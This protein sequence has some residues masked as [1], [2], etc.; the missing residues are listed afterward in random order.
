MQ[1]VLRAIDEWGGI[2]STA[3][4]RA[5]GVDRSILDLLVMYG[6][7]VRVKK[8]LWARPGLPLQVRDAQRL[9]GRLACVSALAFHGLIDPVAGP[10]HISAP[11]GVAKWRPDTSR[12]GP[13]RHWSRRALP[14][15]RFAV[16]A[17]AAW[18]QFGLC[19]H[20]AGRDVRL[21]RPDSL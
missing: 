19:R 3:E 15:D 9:G 5:S 1:F 14:G 18:R 10:L 11:E 21:P 2:A 6:L 12:I 8:G 13:V 16:S 4:L 17:Q 20:V 7:V